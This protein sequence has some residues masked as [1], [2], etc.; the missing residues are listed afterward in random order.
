[1]P[2]ARARSFIESKSA[3][4]RRAVRQSARNLSVLQA[5][6][7]APDMIDNLIRREWFSQE[8]GNAR[9]HQAV[10]SI[11]SNKSGAQNNR[12]FGSNLAQPTKVFFSVHDRHC[13]IEQNRLVCLWLSS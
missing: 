4:D 12:Y 10:E 7:N 8:P 6:E 1:M 13:H 3:R 9:F 2:R 5:I 11:L